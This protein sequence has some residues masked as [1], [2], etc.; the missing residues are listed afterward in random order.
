M[1]FSSFVFFVFFVAKNHFASLVK[2]YTAATGASTAAHSA[3]SAAAHDPH[4]LA[5]DNKL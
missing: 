4:H 5:P 1:G 2:K 3:A